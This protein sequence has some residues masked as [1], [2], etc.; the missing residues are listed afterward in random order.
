MI[1][2]ILC[3]SVVAVIGFVDARCFRVN[4]FFK[5]GPLLRA[6]IQILDVLSDS[7]LAIEIGT[8]ADNNPDD[9]ILPIAFSICILFIFAPSLVSLLQVYY[10]SNAK[11][12]HS[13]NKMKK[14]LLRHSKILYLTAVTTGSAFTAVEIM[15]SSLFGLEL[16]EM[17]LTQRQLISFKTHRIYSVVA[18]EN[19]PQLILQTWYILF[20]D[21]SGSIIAICSAV[22]SLVSII[23]TV[24]SMFMERSLINAQ[25]HTLIEI[26]CC[27]KVISTHADRLKRRVNQIEKAIAGLI[28][29]DVAL[30]EML[31]VQII[32]N[33]LMLLC[34]RC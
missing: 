3:F 22:F 1:S 32:P 20:Y 31:K 4:D 27:G 23:V 21:R 34:W 19:I 12:A 11:W 7:F 14:W 9:Q 16:F 29:I 30:L 33:G 8:E 24:L 2:L 15:N 13:S 10:F 28:G 25:Q 17:G 26:D 6:L 18:L 5:L